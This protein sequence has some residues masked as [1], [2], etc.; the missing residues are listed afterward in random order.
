MDR[1]IIGLLVG[2]SKHPKLSPHFL[3]RGPGERV[4]LP[5]IKRGIYK[6]NYAIY[7]VISA[8]LRRH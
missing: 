4:V 8:Q 1:L 6:S 3:S 2:E 5:E 7:G